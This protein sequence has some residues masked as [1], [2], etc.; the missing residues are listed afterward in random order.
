MVELP[1]GTVTFLFTDLQ[2]S[3]RLWEQYPEAMRAAL[4]RHD[5]ILRRA[6]QACGGH[7]VGTRGDG[8]FAVFVTAH[9]AI[10]AAVTAQCDLGGAVWETPQPLRV[11]MG[12]HSGVAEVRDGDYYGT[13]VNRAA[14]IAAAAHGG[15]IVASGISVDLA[16]DNVG[17]SI[18]MH[19]LGEHRLRDLERPERMVQIT[20][21]GLATEFPPL[22]SLD[23]FP[24]NLPVQRTRFVG[25]R[26]ELSE[27]TGL[28]DEAA[29]VTLIGVG[30]VGKTRLALQVADDALPR[31]PDGAWFVDLAP[32]FDGDAVPD[33][34][35]TVLGVTS[36]P[37][38]S[39]DVA[40]AGHLRVQR[41]LLVLDN[42]EHVLDRTARLVEVI[43][44]QCPRIVVLATSREALGVVSE[45]TYSVS[46]LAVPSLGAS[47]SE[48]GEAEAVQLFQDRARAARSDYSL[49]VDNLDGVVTI[50]RRLDGIPL[51]LELAAARVASL[52]PAQIAERLN[53]RFRILTAGRRTAVERHQTLRATIDWSYDLLTAQE[54][55]ALNRMAVFAGGCALDA[56]EAVLSGVE[57]EE[58]EVVDL[59]GR[60][61]EQSLVLVD[62]SGNE[63]RYRLFETIRQYAA[64]RLADTKDTRDALA[65]H[66]AH[67]RNLA[68]LIGDRLQGADENAWVARYELELEN[69]RSAVAWFA[70]Q[71]DAENAL[72]LV[73]DLYALKFS[74]AMQTIDDLAVAALDAPSSMSHPLGPSAMVLA[75]DHALH[76]GHVQQATTL[77]SAATEAQNLLDTSCHPIA[78]YIRFRIASSIGD[79]DEAA[80]QVEELGRRPDVE[81][82][83]LLAAW[84]MLGRAFVTSFV[85]DKNSAAPLFREATELAR[86]TGN[87]S[88]IALA[89]ASL[90]WAIRDTAPD[91]AL[92]LLDEAIAIGNT[93]DMSLS[94]EVANRFVVSA[95]LG[96]VSS[97]IA[98][99]RRVLAALERLHELN[100]VAAAIANCSIGL[101]ALDRPVA[102]AM[103]FA[104]AASHSPLVANP[105]WGWQ[106]VDGQV[107]DALGATQ[108]NQCIERGRSL[109]KESAIMLIRTELDQIEARLADSTDTTTTTAP[110]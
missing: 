109:D 18:V 70:N 103:L 63:G 48:A 91:R 82:N 97:S 90:A 51:A 12:V 28:L 58:S 7:V 37:G 50:C 45:S 43:A 41:L 29:V 76:E 34:V 84:T 85:A 92:S 39:L 8:L 73:F 2:G 104:A 15:Q 87:P 36:V 105:T 56:A 57:I 13:A 83:N 20:T 75:A 100:Y 26:R 42:C 14:R 54:Q 35:A 16:S 33:T 9:D 66:A 4:P 69:L 32:L 55:R 89:L 24:G 74:D 102:A 11:R 30:G 1:S 101:A 94:M 23:A 49:T 77:L 108:F 19:P 95:R 10:R 96:H 21:E 59:L 98:D 61:V 44:T 81:G 47:L 78:L 6:V 71:D 88:C 80:A 53:E 86:P 17:A 79:L 52:H 99:G 65:R 31:F 60:L 67:Y 40:I 93:A 68:R 27:L 72:G 22:R 110:N 106:H 5:E 62:E 38:T 25:R 107:R 64:E 46:A 3:T